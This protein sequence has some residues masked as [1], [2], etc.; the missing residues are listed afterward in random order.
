[1]HTGETAPPKDS[2]L[3]QM[4]LFNYSE[5]DDDTAVLA[6]RA[7]ADIQERIGRI[8]KSTVEIG[9]SLRDV[10]A[11]MPVRFAS[12]LMAETG[13]LAKEADKLIAIADYA[14][15]TPQLA[16]SMAKF[17]KETQF[18]LIGPGTPESAREEASTRAKT[19]EKI[20]P[21]K[22]REI[23]K[24]HK[25]AVPRPLERAAARKPRPQKP[26]AVVKPETAQPTEAVA[27]TC[28]HCGCTEKTPCV[29][30]GDPCSWTDE[31]KT[32]CDACLDLTHS[33]WERSNITLTIQFFPNDGNPKGRHVSIGVV[34]NQDTPIL[35]FVRA[36]ELAMEFSGPV[37]DAL[38]ALRA[39]LPERW[40]RAIATK[41][42]EAQKEAQAEERRKKNASKKKPGKGPVSSR[43]AKP[44]PKPASKKARK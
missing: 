13:M 29:V 40:K 18:V 32:E 21:K 35:K 22:A 1:M 15:K 2:A 43:Q 11:A 28:R 14:D 31:T 17:S 26:V 3:T 10:K 27:G 19:K 24:R 44:K 8:Q 6:R 30:A 16:A 37:A 33:A 4:S 42:L 36:S 41:R 9:R 39:E 38:D 34:N 12:W 7:A 5:L 23:V 20:T 25:A